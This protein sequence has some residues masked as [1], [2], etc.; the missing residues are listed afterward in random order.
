MTWNKR[1]TTLEG[2]NAFWDRYG[3]RIAE[4]GRSQYA[5]L[6]LEDCSA[7]KAIGVIVSNSLSSLMFAIGDAMMEPTEAAKAADEA[8][9]ERYEEVMNEEIAELKA[10]MRYK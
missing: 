5:A 2:A 8:I 6:P 7:T 10:D 9:Q 4:H 3:W 1:I